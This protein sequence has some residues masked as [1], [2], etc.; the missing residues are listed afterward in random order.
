MSDTKVQNNK[1]FIGQQTYS[2]TPNYI[3]VIIIY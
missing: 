2:P 1:Y 3:I